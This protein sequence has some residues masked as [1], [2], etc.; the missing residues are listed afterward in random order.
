MGSILSTARRRSEGAGGEEGRER[1]KEKEWRRY[2]KFSQEVL[3]F[4][5]NTLL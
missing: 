2:L 4:S 1:G 3:S 5:C